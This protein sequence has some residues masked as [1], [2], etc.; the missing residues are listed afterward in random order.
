MERVHQTEYA[1]TRYWDVTNT[2]SQTVTV[3]IGIDEMMLY[4]NYVILC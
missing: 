3:F 4:N 1:M 2:Y